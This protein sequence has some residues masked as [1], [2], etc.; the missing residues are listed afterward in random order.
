LL[1]R[2]DVRSKRQLNFATIGIWAAD[3]QVATLEAVLAVLPDQA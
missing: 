2:A 3:S 1:L